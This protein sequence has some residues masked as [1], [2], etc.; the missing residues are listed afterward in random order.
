MCPVEL[1]ARKNSEISVPVGVDCAGGDWGE[2]IFDRESNAKT[3]FTPGYIGQRVNFLYVSTIRKTGFVYL[4][5][6][7][8]GLVVF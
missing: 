2:Q 1:S 6:V 3:V 7:E 4:L 8:E 5:W